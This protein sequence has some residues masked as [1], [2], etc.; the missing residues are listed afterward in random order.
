MKAKAAIFGVLRGWRRGARVVTA[1]AAIAAG[2]GIAYAS[3]PEPP[4]RIPMEA[5]GYRNIPTQ[6]MLSGG[7]L[8]TV[9]FVDRDHLLVTFAIHRLL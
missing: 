6:F 4:L 3:G 7:T 5:M 2:A 9:D 1:V 8:L